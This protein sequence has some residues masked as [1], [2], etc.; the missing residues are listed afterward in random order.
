MKRKTKRSYHDLFI[1]LPGMKRTSIFN[2]PFN[3]QVICTRVAG[4]E[5]WTTNGYSDTS[6]WSL[7]GGEFDGEKPLKLDVKG[8]I[9]VDWLQDTNS[10][11]LRG[12][13]SEDKAKLG[14]K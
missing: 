1:T 5:V 4:W 10:G 14:S 12:N 7:L 3:L 2:L 11:P 9:I 6:K 13:M 8:D